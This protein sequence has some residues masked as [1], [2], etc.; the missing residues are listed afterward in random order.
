MDGT[1]IG[2]PG[3]DA[4]AGLFGPLAGATSA[5]EGDEWVKTRISLSLTCTKVSI[6]SINFWMSLPSSA[7]WEGV[8]EDASRANFWAAPHLVAS[9]TRLQPR[10]RPVSQ[11]FQPRA[12][13]DFTHL[14]G[15]RRCAAR[16]VGPRTCGHDAW[17]QN[18]HRGG[19]MRPDLFAS[20]GLRWDS[21]SQSIALPEGRVTPLR[22]GSEDMENSGHPCCPGE[23]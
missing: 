11:T 8:G 10:G 3:A 7:I 13:W 6:R 5:A 12:A 4:A 9:Y 16:G 17:G 15:H 19:D 20:M 18:K 1:S 14:G 2:L 22:A 21:L 23:E